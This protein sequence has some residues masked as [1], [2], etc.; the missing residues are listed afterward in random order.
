MQLDNFRLTR[1]KEL[2]NDID[3]L[4]RLILKTKSKRARKGLERV[5]ELCMREYDSLMNV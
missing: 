5:I 2:T 4:D 1:L 3:K